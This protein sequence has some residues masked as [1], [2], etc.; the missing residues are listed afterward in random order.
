MTVFQDLRYA[1]RTLRRSP[2]FSA[3]AILILAL[4]I[5]ANTAIFSVVRAVLLRPLPFHEP[6]RLAW[7]WATRAD[8]DK[9]FYSI[10]NF[11][12]TRAA[13]RGF[14]ELAAFS[15][16]G[17]TLSGGG[18]PERLSAV[19]VTGNT[20]VALGTGTALG[21]GLDGNDAE[22]EASRVAVISHGLW[23]RRFG[24][25]PAILGR[26]LLLNGETF[27]VVGVLPREFLF[28]GADDAELAVPL[29]LA[30]DPRREERGSNFL[31][32]FGK[33][34]LGVAPSRAQ[35]ELASI[36]DDLRRRYPEENGKLTAPR[37][38]PLTDEIVG[39][40]RRTLL[41]LAG[42]VALLLLVAC[43]NLAALT[44]VRGYG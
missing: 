27:T 39:G 25:D 34:P 44:L 8:R 23:T 38:L 24:A 43:A 15:L 7:V 4:G 20:F 18:E 42:A 19:R 41:I 2:G 6:A 10:P 33:L 13:A 26:P 5:G 16:W 1:L 40:S 31:R 9:A 17:P 32:V 21:R 14:E 12:D 37:V 3:A 11:R 29:S 30:A 35:S 22:P 36:T 28:P